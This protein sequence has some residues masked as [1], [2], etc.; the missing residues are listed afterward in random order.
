[1]GRPGVQSLTTRWGC[2][3]GWPAEITP[4]NLLRVMPAEGSEPNTSPGASAPVSLRRTRLGDADAM[5]QLEAARQGTVTPEMDYV[6][7]RED[8]DPE[9]VRGE[10]AR[11]RM[12]IPANVNH[13]S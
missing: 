13:L 4:R 11:G 10:V 5:T 2:R 1:A 3:P 9:L 6:A 8:L 7:R 12:V